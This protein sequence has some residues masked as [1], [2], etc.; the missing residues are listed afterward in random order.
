MK[1]EPG[2]LRKSALRALVGPLIVGEPV[3]NI[4][5]PKV[6]VVEAA[7]AVE[8]AAIALVEAKFRVCPL[9]STDVRGTDQKYLH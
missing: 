6:A 5:E 8:E 1:T 2:T 9:I 4:A 7:V 3:S